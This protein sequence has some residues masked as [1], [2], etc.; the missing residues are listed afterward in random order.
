M[1]QKHLAGVGAVV[2][3]ASLIG[4]DA[5][6]F[7]GVFN[8]REALTITQPGDDNCQEYIPG[9]GSC[10]PARTI[11]LQPGQFTARA[12]LGLSSGQK[13]IRLEVDNANPP[14]AV[15]LNFNSNIP[16]N[17]HFLLAAAQ[18]KQN[19]DLTGDI[20][21]N[22][23][24]TQQQS[25]IESCTYEVPQT[26][27][28]NAELLKGF[29]SDSQA[30]K[31][32]TAAADSLG[33]EDK[34]LFGSIPQSHPQPGPGFGPGH[35]PGPGPGPHSGPGFGPGPHPGPSQHPQPVCHTQ[36]VTR[37]GYQSVNFYYETTA[38]NITAA[39]L[40][41]NK[42]LADYQGNGSNTK[43]VYTYQSSCQ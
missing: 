4:C 17:G 26:V 35:G 24:Q 39:F 8:V 37:Y 43:K 34:G 10:K 5:I 25:A 2:L 16:T 20:V 1:K 31:D 3:M 15:E 28:R 12:D 6:I 42:T 29:D 21:T 18:I 13:Q 40:Q 19:F 30:L 22:V 23:T 32:L 7:S 14:T 41:G 33:L 11:V 38:S 9:H 36:W 27:C